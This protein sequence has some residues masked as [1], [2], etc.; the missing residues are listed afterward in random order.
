M[1]GLPFGA[2][3]D[4]DQLVAEQ[5]A[6]DRLR[7]LAAADELHAVLAGD[8]GDRPLAAA[9]GVDLGLDDGGFRAEARERV[10][11]GLRRIGDDA[12]RHR[13]AGFAED[14]L[15]LVFVNL[16]GQPYRLVIFS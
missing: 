9:A 1:D 16:H 4:R 11:G 6:G 5:I 8:F 3:L 2:G 13:D 7:L 14:L 15:R 12:A 10:G